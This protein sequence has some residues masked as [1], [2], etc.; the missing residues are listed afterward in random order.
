MIAARVYLIVNVYRRAFS[1]LARRQ[2]ATLLEV[3]AQMNIFLEFSK[4][5]IIF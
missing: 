4:I 5:C 3:D 2:Y 1:K